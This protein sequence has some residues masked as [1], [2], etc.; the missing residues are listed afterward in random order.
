[1][2]PLVSILIP[3]RNRPA[4]LIKAINS[5]LAQ[6]YKQIEI[7]ITDNSDADQSCALQAFIEDKRVLYIKNLENIGP[8]LNWRKALESS[9][10]KYCLILPDDDYLLNPFY[11]EDAVRILSDEKVSLVVPDCILSYPE[12]KIIGKS[13]HDGYI[14]G[15]EFIR[16]GHHI[17][18]IGNVFRKEMVLRLDAFHSNDVLWSDIELW[19]RIMSLGGVYCYC[20][21]SALYLFHDS[22]IVLNMT[23]SELIVNSR[24]IRSSVESFADEALIYGLVFSYLC[25]IDGFGVDL[26]FDF[27]KSVMKK[28]N[29]KDGYIAMYFRLLIR[30]LKNDI[31]LLIRNA[32]RNKLPRF[33]K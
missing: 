25:A 16:A 21:P 27:V 9:R 6:T 3:T 33:V 7:V 29:I 17:P 13:G 24:F 22:N 10:G 5:A 4:L 19:R 20:I 32:V 30:R 1:M 12:I 26:D 2:E 28:N 14:N 8:I 11:I 18:H 23:R 15:K 31:K